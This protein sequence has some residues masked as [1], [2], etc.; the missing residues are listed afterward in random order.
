MVLTRAAGM[1]Q[2]GLWTALAGALVVVRLPS[3]VQPMG[4]DQALYA[5]VGQR[6]LAGDVPYRDAWDQKPPAIHFV[7]ALMRALWPHDSAVAAADLL[8]AA[9]VAG[10][11][12]LVG[13]VIDERSV[14]RVTAGSHRLAGSLGNPIGIASALV[15]L[16]LS[17]P[18]FTRVAG[19]RLRSQCET[20]IA[21]A[22][23]GAFLLLTRENARTVAAGALLGFA[24][25]LKYNAIVY[26]GGA[27]LVLWLW[28]RWSSAN[29]A[30]LAAGF[31]VVPAVVLA[32]FA[33]A[34][35]LRP[36]YDATI[37]YNVRYSGETYT[38]PWHAIGYLLAFPVDRARVDALWTLG[39]V[40]CAILIASAVG[41]RKRL[42]PPLW[43]AAACLSIAINGNRG[44]PQYFVQA[45]PALALAAGWGSV[46]A[47]RALRKLEG[48]RPHV[49]G[50]AIV[51][52]VAI[53]VWRVN[54]FPKLIEQTVFD[55]RYA[56]GWTSRTDY[57][58]RYADDR[59]Y[60]AL[61]A[62]LLGNV[63]RRYSTDDDRVYVFG[64]TC[65]A[66]VYA[67][68]ASASKFF[69]SRPV[70]AGFNAGQPGYGIV[71][72]LD[73]LQRN[74]PAVVAL[75]RRDWAPDVTD[76]AEFFMRTPALATWLESH[77]K[78]GS[79][80]DGF[81]VWLRTNATP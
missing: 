64:F 22:V 31:A 79:G 60:S 72:L 57:L 80:P 46:L 20:F 71:G 34:G 10:M 61:A 32:Y 75:Q 54:Q 27:I 49:I 45:N 56:L 50:A 33:A 23:T 70:I 9:A 29:V 7:Y 36:L 11:L 55:A 66:Y 53:G 47:W 58:A 73:E 42:L 26:A 19:V 25:A 30:R 3:L 40:G 1:M 28:D 39:G 5:Y 16:L 81:E 68:R 69:W 52:V 77:Y 8:A 76:S 38:G 51:V 44:L 37:A 4:A 14:T 18:S 74:T 65:G 48:S 21:L 63:L 62:T 78:P 6:L 15:F 13:K 17:N 35:A 43:V 24:F 41:R 67:G 12:F 59:K 2:K